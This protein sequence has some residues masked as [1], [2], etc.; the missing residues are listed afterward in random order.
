MSNKNVLHEITINF[1]EDQIALNAILSVPENSALMVIFVHG[2][3]SGRFSPRN[4]YVA[5]YL[6]KHGIATL[7]PD[8]LTSDED[9][10]DQITR[11]YRFDIPLLTKRLLGITAW[12]KKH[13]SIKIGYFGASTGAA[14][15]LIAGAQ[16][17]SGISAIVSRGGRPDL[18]MEYLPEVKSPTLLIV[19]GNDFDVIR[20][21]QAAYSKLCCRKELQ[22][23]PHA[24]HLFEEAGALESVAKLAVSWFEKFL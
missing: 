7:L 12:S 17:G 19:G 10:I 1:P 13:L 14:A 22:I 8:L 20:L 18:A 21:N 9:S 11:E 4:Q 2:S 16:L 24:T 3:G 5:E 6:N 15:A 23:V